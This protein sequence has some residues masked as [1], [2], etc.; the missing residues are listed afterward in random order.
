MFLGSGG[1]LRICFAWL[2]RKSSYNVFKNIN[3]QYNKKQNVM[4]LC[5]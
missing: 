2:A 5:I 4:L 3:D 1:G